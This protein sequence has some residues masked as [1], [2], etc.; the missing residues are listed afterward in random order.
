MFKVYSFKSRVTSA[1]PFL[2]RA[3]DAGAPGHPGCRAGSAPSREG[4]ALPARGV[5]LAK[6]GGAR[7]WSL[8][9]GSPAEPG[10]A[11]AARQAPIPN[12]PA[13]GGQLSA[14]VLR[15]ASPPLK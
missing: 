12:P 13:S 15:R 11:R 2:G 7:D 3:A 6:D 5:D 14:I 10:V 4:A 8:A 9:T 1:R